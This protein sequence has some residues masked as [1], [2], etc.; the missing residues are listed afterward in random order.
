M[1][2]RLSLGYGPLR[3]PRTDLDPTGGEERT[4]DVD[5]S[6]I[7]HDIQSSAGSITEAN[8]Q[9]EE[10]QSHSSSKDEAKCHD[11]AVEQQGLLTT[12]VIG[13]SR[14]IDDR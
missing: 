3:T 8:S 12:L 4:M 7:F 2:W 11:P 13:F 9:S 5:R 14:T 1:L 6:V 10:V